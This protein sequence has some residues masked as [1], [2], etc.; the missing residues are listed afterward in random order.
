VI[1]VANF[2]SI[3]FIE[4]VSIAA[5]FYLCLLYMSFYSASIKFHLMSA[6]DLRELE[7]YL[8]D[9]LFRNLSHGKR[10]FEIQNLPE[11]MIKVYLRYRDSDV[12]KMCFMI[13]QVLKQL[14]SKSVITQSQATLEV[15][16]SLNRLQCSKCFYICYLS[17][18]EPKKC[19]RCFSAQLHSFPDKK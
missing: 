3:Q 9:H 18:N 2:M 15:P 13:S 4:I 17:D 16:G 6:T 7:W 19:F 5:K 8:R 10:K 14:S 1:N 11:E 12:D